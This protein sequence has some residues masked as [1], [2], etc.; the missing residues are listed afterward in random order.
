MTRIGVKCLDKGGH[1]ETVRSH[2][3]DKI[4]TGGGIHTGGVVVLKGLVVGEIIG[5]VVTIGGESLG[6]VG[7]WGH[8]HVGRD[9]G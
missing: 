5:H 8:P 2:S 1:E 4:E 6:G 3:F 7:G 9:D